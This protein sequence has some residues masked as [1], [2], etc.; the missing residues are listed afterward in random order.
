MAPSQKKI[1][2]KCKALESGQIIFPG[3][4]FPPEEEPYASCL[5]GPARI[6]PACCSVISCFSNPLASCFLLSHWLWRSSRSLGLVCN[7]DERVSSWMAGLSLFS[8]LSGACLTQSWTDRALGAELFSDNS[9]QLRRASMSV[10]RCPEC[11]RD[12]HGQSWTSRLI[13][14]QHL[15]ESL[16][17]ICHTSC[18]FSPLSHL[19]S[20]TSISGEH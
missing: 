13:G 9:P 1:N 6:S 12:G 19:Q 2:A 10:C 17:I 14:C 8:F 7:L 16:V 20:S 4:R 11:L 15:E 18:H 3:H 5:A